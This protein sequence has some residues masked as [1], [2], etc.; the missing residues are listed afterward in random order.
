MRLLSLY[1]DVNTVNC[2]CSLLTFKLLAGHDLFHLEQAR[3][4]LDA[5]RARG[6]AGTEAR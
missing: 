6:G 5:V 2:P 4:T 3:Q 1:P